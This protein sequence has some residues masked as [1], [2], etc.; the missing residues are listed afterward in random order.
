MAATV[1][2]D[3]VSPTA[4]S[5][6]K[7]NLYDLVAPTSLGTSSCLFITYCPNLVQCYIP[8]E[9]LDIARAN[10]FLVLV[11][12]DL[13]LGFLLPFLGTFLIFGFWKIGIVSYPFTLPFQA[14]LS[15][16]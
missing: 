5:L 9:A 15:L 11:L 7:S 3:M 13:A 12:P 6:V 1:C 8:A 2:P 16:S 4:R 14:A 10:G